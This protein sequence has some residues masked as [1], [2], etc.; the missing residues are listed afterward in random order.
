MNYY[1]L[2]QLIRAEIAAALVSGFVGFLIGC[3][4]Q[5]V[6]GGKGK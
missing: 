5:K 4:L 3:W 2:E 1:T 6:K